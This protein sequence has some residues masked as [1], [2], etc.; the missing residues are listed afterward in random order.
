M[1]LIESICE[2]QCLG[3]PVSFTAWVRRD[4]SGTYLHGHLNIHSPLTPHGVIAGVVVLLENEGW[5]NRGRERGE[6]E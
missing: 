2:S 1:E 4:F 3:E 5:M 6:R